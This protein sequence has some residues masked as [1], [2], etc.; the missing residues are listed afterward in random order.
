MDRMLGGG[1]GG[2]AE[3]QACSAIVHVSAS[4]EGDPAV[5]GRGVEQPRAQPRSLQEPWLAGSCSRRRL[6][7]W[8]RRQVFQAW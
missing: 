6:E 8:V 2:K 4:F 1:G 5:S 7:K 3:P